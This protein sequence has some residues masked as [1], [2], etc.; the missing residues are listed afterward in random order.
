MGRSDEG[1]V[2]VKVA[3]LVWKPRGCAHKVFEMAFDLPSITDPGDADL[4][5]R[6]TARMDE[7]I[8]ASPAWVVRDLVEACEA[9]AAR[10]RS[11]RPADM[12]TAPTAV[13][14]EAGDYQP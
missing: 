2:G 14:H 1:T 3:G 13:E 7:F 5:A 8:T 9:I 6:I 4:V 10:V 12:Q 11:L